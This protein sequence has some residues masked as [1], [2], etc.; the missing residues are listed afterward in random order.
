MIRGK[1]V[2]GGIAIAVVTLAI[3][4]LH[5][6]GGPPTNTQG[7]TVEA[8]GILVSVDSDAGAFTFAGAS[9]TQEFYVT[10]DTVIE[11]GKTER[12][13]FRD[14]AHF[15]GTTGVVLSADTGERQDANRITLLVMPF[16]KALPDG[17]RDRT[18]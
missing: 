17:E 1:S 2:V 6:V 14:L 18:R 11:L 15:I 4:W 13:P 8:H 5:S 9:G 16:R 10:P 12:I 7:P 3:A